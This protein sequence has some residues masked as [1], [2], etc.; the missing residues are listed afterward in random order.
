MSEKIKK[1]LETPEVPEELRPENIPVLIEKSAKQKR[2]KITVIRAAVPAVACLVLVAGMIKFFPF[3]VSK[4]S[5]INNYTALND[6]IKSDDIAS[7][8]NVEKAE[9]VIPAAT[10][11][12]L[13]FVTVESYDEIYEKLR[14]VRDK[15][16][17]IMNGADGMFTDEEDI[18]LNESVEKEFESSPDND[19]RDDSSVESDEVY[20]TLSQVEGIAEADIIKAT[21]DRVFYVKENALL[22]VPFDNKTGKFGDVS[23]IELTELTNNENSTVYIKDM[24]LENK[25]LSVVC[26]VDGMTSKNNTESDPQLSKSPVQVLQTFT[27]VFS[28]DVS[29]SEP[30]YLGSGYQS[31]SY[32]SSRMKDG[33]IYLVSFQNA[34]YDGA[35]SKEDTER[36]IPCVGNDIN[37]L[38][39]LDVSSVYV[40]RDW[41]NMSENISYRNISGISV[42][43]PGNPISS[44]SIAGTYGEIFCSIDNL[45]VSD[46]KYYEETEC[47]S[48]TR[49]S[50]DNGVITPAASGEVEGSVRNQFSMDEY[51]GYFRAATTSYR[52]TDEERISS[53]NVF[54]LDMNMNTVGSLTGLAENETIKSVTFNGNIAYVVTYEQTDPLFAVNLEDPSAPV[55]TDEYK[56]NGYSSFLR[57]WSDDLLLG[58]GVDATDEGI[59]T[60][61]KLVMF[62]VS[63][64]GDLKEC[65]FWSMSGQSY[66]A[67][68]SSA[69]WDRKALLIDSRRNLIGFPLEDYR[70]I[71]D[72]SIYDDELQN[73][74]YKNSL[75]WYMLFSYDNGEFTEIGRVKAGEESYGFDRG[76][77]IGDYLCT[78]S[79]CEIVCTDLETMEETDRVSVE[80][81]KGQMSY[82]YYYD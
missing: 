16:D 82:M 33:I 68:S 37:S 54:I 15:N 75:Y 60:G 14:F 5:N 22:N 80:E 61:V 49:I 10:S 29:G 7:E 78:F 45:Y 32:T 2:S 26:T 34:Y 39:C 69:V 25:I 6:S 56:I 66:H 36:Y 72:T 28:F 19:Y 8:S 81:F 24:Y 35:Y 48:F 43:D 59:E 38:K 9:S 53:N 13:A 67:V 64:S 20:D 58:F 71:Y 23:Q 11:E 40:P 30:T 57:K 79:T 76:I 51:N 4:E 41:E 1:V 27:G 77:Y 17:F 42:K 70:N 12:D 65:G 50:L 63:D 73:E 21:S 47:T 55:V 44:V 31:G 46:M 52:D 18:T 3:Q 74:Q 62:D